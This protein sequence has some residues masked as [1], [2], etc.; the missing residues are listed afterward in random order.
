[1]RSGINRKTLADAMGKDEA[2]LSRYLSDQHEHEMGHTTLMIFEA[3]TGDRT[4]MDYIEREL[5]RIAQEIAS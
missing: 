3:M 2:T 1:M 5:G 4:V